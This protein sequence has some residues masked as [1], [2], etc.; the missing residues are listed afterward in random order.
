[1]AAVLKLPQIQ[2]QQQRSYLAPCTTEGS[3]RRV[4]QF[5]EKDLRLRSGVNVIN[6]RKIVFTAIS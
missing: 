6:I 4:V 5:L 3:R 2:Q 1:M